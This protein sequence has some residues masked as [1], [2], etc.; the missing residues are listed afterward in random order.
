[1]VLERRWTRIPTPELPHRE[2]FQDCG[3]DGPDFG[4]MVISQLQMKE[5]M[6]SVGR[7]G[8]TW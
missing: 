2:H 1:M 3:H 4:R 6:M 7:Y 5:N 8:R